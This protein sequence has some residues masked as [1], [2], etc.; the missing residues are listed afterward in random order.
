MGRFIGKS[1]VF[2]APFVVLSLVEL[3]LLP[4]DFFTFRV[5]EAVIT[6]SYKFPGLFYPNQH[7]I[8]NEAPDNPAF[9]HKKQKIVEW[10][11][12]DYGFRNRPRD[13]EPDRYDI[14][15]I[16]DSNFAGS[17]LD[18]RN[19]LAE[20]LQRKCNCPVYSYSPGSSVMLPYLFSDPRIWKTPPRAIVFEVRTGELYYKPYLFSVFLKDRTGR[21]ILKSP[22]PYQSVLP[23]PL[24]LLVDRL[25][26]QNMVQFIRSKVGS[27]VYKGED[28]SSMLPL[29]EAIDFSFRALLTLKEEAGRR[30]T[31]FIFFLMPSQDRK[32]DAV[33]HRLNEAGVKTIAFLPTPE[34]PS[35]IDLDWY[36]QR[37]DS[38][39][40]EEAVDYAADKIL[41]L[42]PR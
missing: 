38:H 22:E 20:V 23:V 14:V 3:F 4:I 32:V 15:I 39:W 6:R 31:E 12:D 40:R 28:P 33:I 30:G 10:Y 17:Y 42:L 19:T 25:Y 41:R 2:L 21:L 5:W 9:R 37:E 11:T 8:K 7:I 35:G 26:K 36:Y 24:R 13:K 16:G 29:D 1:L 18:Q 34:A 27:S